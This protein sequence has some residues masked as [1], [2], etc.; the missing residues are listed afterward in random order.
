MQDT[1]GNPVWARECELSHSDRQSHMGLGS[2]CPLT[3]SQLCS[4][5]LSFSLFNCSRL[6]L[7]NCFHMNYLCLCQ[8]PTNFWPVTE[9]KLCLCAQI[10]KSNYPD[11]GW[12][13]LLLQVLMI[14]SVAV[15]FLTMG[16][17]MKHMGN[18]LTLFYM[19]NF[20]HHYRVIWLVSLSCQSI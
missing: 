15:S 8:F 17:G 14:S 7:L 10:V 18:A 2:S 12:I 19:W 1:T 4:K 5:S 13:T 6:V 9:S 3:E 11:Y 20:H 16:A